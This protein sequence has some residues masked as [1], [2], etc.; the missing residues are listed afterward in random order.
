MKRLKGGLQT[1]LV[2]NEL[3]SVN[4]IY[5]LGKKEAMALPYVG[6]QV[7]AE[8][9]RMLCSSGGKRKGSG[10]KAKD[11]ATGLVGVYFRITREQRKKIAIMGGS[12]WLRKVIDEA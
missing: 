7:W 9:K 3:G 10:R 8:A 11:G 1:A 2:M 12:V 5:A 4:D 6:P